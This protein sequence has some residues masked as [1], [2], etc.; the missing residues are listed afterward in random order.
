[1]GSGSGR[2]HL[3]RSMQRKVHS[4]LGTLS[5]DDTVARGGHGPQERLVTVEA[6]IRRGRGCHRA[7]R[8]G[9]PP[10]REVVAT[11]GK[12]L[13]AKGVARTCA[14]FKAVREADEGRH[15]D[16]GHTHKLLCSK[17]WRKPHAHTRTEVGGESHRHTH[18]RTHTASPTSYTIEW[19]CIPVW[20]HGPYDV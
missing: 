11:R 4:A 20:T 19:A 1:M 7:R 5:H 8:G 3:A 13:L 14:N 6:H 15:G 17:R 9:V 10:W 2:A 12:L 18:K 16:E